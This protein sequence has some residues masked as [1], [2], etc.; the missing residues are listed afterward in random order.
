MSKLQFDNSETGKRL[1]AIRRLLHTSMNRVTAD[2]MRDKSIIYDVNWGVALPRIKEI[3]AMY[4]ADLELAQRLWEQKIRESMILAS[5]LAPA[6]DFPEENLLQW[7]DDVNN[8]ELAEQ[9][10]MNLLARLPEKESVSLMLVQSDNIW[11]QITG[12]TLAT[13]ISSSYSDSDVNRFLRRAIELA[14]SEEF[15]LYKSIATALGRLC[16]HSSDTARK[17]EQAV[18]SIADK[19]APGIARIVSEVESEISFLDF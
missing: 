6:D 9:I 15:F 3:A 12:F 18:K 17:V 4:E 5:M 7:L 11:K 19:D 10:A 13:R 2:S 14:E 16:R 1:L 8:I